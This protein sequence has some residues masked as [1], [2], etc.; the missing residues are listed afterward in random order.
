MSKLLYCGQSANN[1]LREIAKLKVTK[2]IPKTQKEHLHEEHRHAKTKTFR[3]V[4]QSDGFF[5]T[6]QLGPKKFSS[7]YTLAL[8][9]TSSLVPIL[10]GL[11]PYYLIIMSPYLPELPHMFCNVLFLTIPLFFLHLLPICPFMD[12]P[13][14]SSPGPRSWSP[15]LR[16]WV[17]IVRHN[18]YEPWSGTQGRLYSKQQFLL[19]KMCSKELYSLVNVTLASQFFHAR[20]PE[21]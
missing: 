11:F 12:F 2:E 13:P 20:R 8:L 1:S 4:L 15:G 3:T 17:F 10:T 16:P 5:Y 7:I 9:G 19:L 6:Y 21:D 14:L 18:N